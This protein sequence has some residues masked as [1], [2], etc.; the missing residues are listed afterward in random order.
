MRKGILLLFISMF[1][2]A[3][4]QAQDTEK[5]TLQDAIDIA[6]EN[7][8][9]LKRAS[10]DLDLARSQNFSAKA[11]F[12][13]S[14][15]GSF[16]GRQ[17]VGRQ[18][19]ES[20]I[21]F[22]E[23]TS[24][25]LS[26]SISTSMPIFQGFSNILNLR[27]SRKDIDRQENSLERTRETVIFNAAS[28]Y[29]Q[30]LLDKQLLEIAEENLEASQ[31]QLKQVEAQVEV[32]SRPTVDL[33]DQ[34]SQVASN[35][36]EVINQENALELS[37]TQLIRNLQL[38]PLKSYEFA[39]PEVA[40]EDVEPQELD[41]QKLTEQALS[42]RKDLRSQELLIETLNNDLKEARY[43]LFPTLSV[44]AGISSGYGDLYS[45]PDPATGEI[46]SVGFVDQFF[47]QRINRY[48]GFQI[49]V[50]IFNNWDRRVSIQQAQVNYKNAQLDLRDQEYAV[51]E[52]VRQAY[53]DYRSYAKR[54]ESSQ[55]SLRA[56]ERS[57]E[58]Q[59]QRYEVGSSTLIELTDASAR[60][61]EAQSNLA[62][63][64]YNLIFQEKL[65]NYYL[66]QLDQDVQIK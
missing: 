61:T 4:L 44:S 3:A 47:D 22:E 55:K 46:R 37:R 33:Y 5:I 27:N 1:L 6:L 2:T 58:T 34:E 18:F 64:L 45:V 21:A 11:N 20:E 16:S 52:E 49:S 19:I 13:P 31:Q 25:T 50:P 36:L 23:V 8:L 53:N 41:L 32:G 40:V 62:N 51:R 28:S 39:M 48:A 38:D 63:A 10:N 26:G 24:N 54:L 12:L 15:D 60:Y 7:N 14:V 29:L 43:A 30:V 66:G 56:A 65:L 9:E 42:N 57:Y 59:Q 35:E 17:S